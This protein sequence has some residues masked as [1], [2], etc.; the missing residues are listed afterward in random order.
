M[1]FIEEKKPLSCSKIMRCV[2]GK[3]DGRTGALSGAEHGVRTGKNRPS[4]AGE[5]AQ[6]LLIQGPPPQETPV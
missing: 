5:R 6:M 1:D 2:E 3:G 4:P